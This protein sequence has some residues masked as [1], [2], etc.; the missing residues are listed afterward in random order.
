MTP[1][2]RAPFGL[3]WG[4]L[5]Q[6]ASFAESTRAVPGHTRTGLPCCQSL[7]AGLASLGLQVACLHL[8]CCAPGPAALAG[9][10]SPLFPRTLPLTLVQSRI[11]GLRWVQQRQGPYRQTAGPPQVCLGSGQTHQ[12]DRGMQPHRATPG[13]WGVQTQRREVG[14]EQVSKPGP[15]ELRCVCAAGVAC[16][17]SQRRGGTGG[18]CH[19]LRWAGPEGQL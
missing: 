2:T 9:Y 3:S 11:Q 16:R 1:G 10:L 4:F 13:F 17:A 18:K 7:S 14:R 6:D 5:K 8:S 12:T 15:A 19:R